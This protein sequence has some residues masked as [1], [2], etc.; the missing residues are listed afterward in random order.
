MTVMSLL[1]QG[2]PPEGGITL[3]ELIENV[4]TD[5]AALFVYALVIAAAFLVWKGSR[6]GP[7]RPRGADRPSAR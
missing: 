5:P 3:R 1:A 2:A 4:P 7:V 6:R